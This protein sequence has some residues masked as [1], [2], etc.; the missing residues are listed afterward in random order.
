MTEQTTYGSPGAFVRYDGRTIEGG[1]CG[2]PSIS[3]CPAFQEGQ[4]FVDRFSAY[5][6]RY[7]GAQTITATAY[8]YWWNGSGWTY[9]YD[10]SLPGGCAAAGGGAGHCTFGSPAPD[11]TSGASGSPIFYPLPFNYAYTVVLTVS[12][13]NRATGA[14]LA[15]ANYRP[16][17]TSADIGCASFAY[18]NGYCNPGSA[19]GLG[20]VYLR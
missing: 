10:R 3:S 4:I 17:A 7:S 2:V 15:R 16:Q 1:V 18:T 20:D 8:L 13:Y 5:S 11:V 12:W 9:W 19:A 14:L 6:T